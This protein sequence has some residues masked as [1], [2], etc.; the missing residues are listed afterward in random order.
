M[1]KF[2]KDL[3]G[4]ARGFFELKNRKGQ[5]EQCPL[6]INL[7]K[8]FLTE[9]PT[10]V[11]R[12]NQITQEQWIQICLRILLVSL[13]KTTHYLHLQKIWYKVKYIF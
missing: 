12:K 6:Y 7:K 10:R 3:L 11:L 1:K 2:R 13:Y 9:Q 8:Q 4:G 5:N